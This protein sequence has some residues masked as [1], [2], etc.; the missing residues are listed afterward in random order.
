MLTRPILSIKNKEV[1]LVNMITGNV[2]QRLLMFQNVPPTSN[3]PLTPDEPTRARLAEYEATIESQTK[4]IE[5]LEKKLEEMAARLGPYRKGKRKSER[6]PNTNSA[7][8]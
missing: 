6:S 2:S 4:R 7:S 1:D 3:D 5:L 8:D